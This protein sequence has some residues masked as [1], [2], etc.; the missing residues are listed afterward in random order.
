MPRRSTISD[1]LILDSA[2]AVFLEKGIRAT[3]AE[4]ARHAGIAEGSIFNRFHTKEELFRASMRLSI[5]AP[6]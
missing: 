2:R 5:E 6:A 1:A 3:T 4:V